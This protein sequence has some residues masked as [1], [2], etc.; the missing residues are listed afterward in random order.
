MGVSMNVYAC[1]QAYFST[2]LY[3]IRSWVWA[4]VFTPSLNPPSDS[5]PT[6]HILA[7][8]HLS[9]QKRR[10]CVQD[11]TPQGN[12]NVCERIRFC[13][14]LGQ[15]EHGVPR[16]SFHNRCSQIPAKGYENHSFKL[17]SNSFFPA[18]NLSSDDI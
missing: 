7:Q 15:P 16:R 4:A 3:S 18:Y 11:R 14:I 5:N 1:S 9:I 12:C 17:L 2:L 13:L 6:L 10:Y 8:L